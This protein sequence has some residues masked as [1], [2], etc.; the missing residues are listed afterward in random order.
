MNPHLTS[1]V[2]G[3]LVPAFFFG[4]I[5]IFSK[6]SGRA[7]IGLASYIVLAGLGVVATGVVMYVLQ[8]GER[9]VTLQSGA[10]AI[11]SGLCWGV[12][13]ALYMLV[14]SKMKAPIADI[15]PFHGAGILFAVGLSF[16]VFAEWKEVHVPTLLIGVVLI[17]VGGVLVAR[18]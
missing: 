2:I 14:L 7:G 15:V 18:S 4:A 11:G 13:M 6:W 3:G 16:L 17:T 1:I 8:K 9:L 10:H 5:S 12:G